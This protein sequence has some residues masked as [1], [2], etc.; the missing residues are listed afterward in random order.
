MYNT[1]PPCPFCQQI[2][3]VVYWGTN[4]SKTRR[5]R[6]KDCNKTFTLDPIAKHI[7]PEKEALIAR[8]LQE[9]LSVEAIARATRCAKRTVYNVLKKTQQTSSESPIPPAILPSN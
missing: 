9:R 3:P 8:L 5:F 1:S 4:E 2:Q 7:S 6:C